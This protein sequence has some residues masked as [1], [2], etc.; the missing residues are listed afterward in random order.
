MQ[1]QG[2]DLRKWC[3]GWGGTETV[4][5]HGVHTIRKQPASGD[6]L[7]GSESS[8]AG[9]GTAERARWGGRWPRRE[10]ARAHLWSMHA[11]TWQKPTQHP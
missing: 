6:L 2:T 8:S 10:G 11:G 5:G 9:P 4:A 1:A 3:G 7:H